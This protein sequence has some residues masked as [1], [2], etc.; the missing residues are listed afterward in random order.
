MLSSF[1]Y[2]ESICFVDSMLF[3]IVKKVSKDLWKGHGLVQ[4]CQKPEFLK[5]ES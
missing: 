4:N 1:F 3:I 2:G 5:F